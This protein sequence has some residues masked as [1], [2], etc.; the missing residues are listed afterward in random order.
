MPIPPELL[1]MG[2]GTV[3]G[4]LFKFMAERAKQRE[5][6]FKMMIQSRELAVKE[7]DAASKRDG[8]SG[9]WVRRFIVISTM[10][11]VILAPFVLALF[12]YPIFTQVTEEKSKY[13]FG[14]F[15]GGTKTKFVELGGYLIIPEVRQTLSAIIGYYFGQSSA[16]SK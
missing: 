2:F 6:Q 10:F 11:G 4:F 16:S 8:E 7:A 5:Q 12:D 13:V 3:T 1:T 9:K 14:L 15:G